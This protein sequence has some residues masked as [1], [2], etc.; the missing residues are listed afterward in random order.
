[1]DKYLIINADDFGMC[2]AGNIAT[3][4]LLE[5]GGV[6][7][8]TIM[9]PCGWALEAV[10]YAIA[11]PEFAIGVHLTTTSEW[12]NYRWRPV[13]DGTPS[14]RDEE[15]YMWHESDQFEEHADLEEAKKEL[16]AQIDFVKNLGLE[17]SHIDN[18]MGSMYG[19]ET[20]RDEL[21]EEVLKI[22]AEYNLPFRLPSKFNDNQISNST[23]GIKIPLALV[24]MVLAQMGELARENNV[25]ILDYLMAHETKSPQGDSFEQYQEYMM[26]HISS[27]PEGFSEM[28]I[29]PAIECDEIKAISNAYRYR[30]WE[31]KI[32]MDPKTRQHIDS[33]GIKLINYRDLVKLRG[34]R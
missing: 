23:F 31:H 11:H 6:T 22:A 34:V 7:S 20:G 25:V 29:H 15:G 1:M 10:R 8:A 18:H 21:L 16:R 30:V 32:F 3:Q 26:N 33:C 24:Q 14:L 19:I 2:K 9:T 12:K 27:I 5:C 13:A 4:Q 17:P 28:Y